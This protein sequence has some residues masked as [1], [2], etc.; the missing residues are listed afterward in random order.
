MKDTF[1]DHKYTQPSFFGG[2]G[3]GGG[4]CIFDLPGMGGTVFS[5]MSEPFSDDEYL[6][7]L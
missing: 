5:K 4:G 3:G 2:G 6:M 1:D 7:A